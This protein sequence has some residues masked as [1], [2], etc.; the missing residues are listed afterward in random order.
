V[1][2][3]VPNANVGL[4]RLAELTLNVTV[5]KALQTSSWT[6]DLTEPQKKYAAI[7]AAAS[8]EVF[9]VLEKMPDLSLRLTVDEAVPGTKVDLIPFNG[10]IPGMA[11][12]AA[13]G[14]IIG[15]DVY[16]CP[17]GVL[18]KNKQ[19]MRV[20]KCT[21]VVQLHAIYAPG[22]I[23]PGFSKNSTAASLG[24]LGK[25]EVIVPIGMLKNH[26]HDP[27][28][29]EAAQEDGITMPAT[30]SMVRRSDRGRVRRIHDP[31]EGY[32]SSENDSRGRSK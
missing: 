21:Y 17:E 18:Y 13:T 12:R 24:D 8:L 30:E 23:L 25:V 29:M 7:D 1:R 15:N 31:M 6:K 3:A 9:E 27:D 10:S 4:S 5:D 32:E 22:L 2:Q 11:A 28:Q 16:S 20:G 26:V 19:R 14:I